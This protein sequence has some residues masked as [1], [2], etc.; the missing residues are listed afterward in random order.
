MVASAV[1][2][3]VALSLGVHVCV[4]GSVKFSARMQHMYRSSTV[5]TRSQVRRCCAKGLCWMLICCMCRT[6]LSRHCACA[7]YVQNR[8]WRRMGQREQRSW[9]LVA[10]L[11]IL[12]LW[13]L[14]FDG[15]PDFLNSTT[16]PPPLEVRTS[17]A[18][19]PRSLPYR[20]CVSVRHRVHACAAACVLVCVGVC[21]CVCVCVCSCAPYM[22]CAVHGVLACV[23]VQPMHVRWLR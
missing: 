1:V 7:H 21:V 23:R 11:L 2:A 18:G 8:R 9:Y 20:A 4:Y 15:T 5:S 13:V 19:G 12:F 6:A 22:R 10:F 16:P 3:R 14:F 17:C